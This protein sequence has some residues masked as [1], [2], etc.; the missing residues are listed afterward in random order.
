MSAASA[1]AFRAHHLLCALGFRGLGYNDAF[2]ENMTAIVRV[3]QERPETVLK[4]V[5]EPDAVCAACPRLSDGDCASGATTRD[6]A[7][8][9]L[10]GLERGALVTA[11]AAYERVKGRL[12][13]D[14][15]SSRVCA[16]CGWA[17]YGY[18]RD[19]LAALRPSDGAGPSPGPPA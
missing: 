4:L 12:T 2:V 15:L 1:M 6:M 19:G 14:I 8:L 13:P 3:L 11:A 5:A 10:L 16:D 17:A 9:E 18:C 7:V